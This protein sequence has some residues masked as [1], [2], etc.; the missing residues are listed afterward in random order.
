MA[1]AD[2][3]RERIAERFLSPAEVAVLRS[4]PAELRHR[5]C[6]TCWT[7]QEAFVKARGD[8]LSLA[9]HGERAREHPVEYELPAAVEAHRSQRV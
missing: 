5:R 2:F 7:R 8:G 9:R 6:L 3:A 1:D 4:L